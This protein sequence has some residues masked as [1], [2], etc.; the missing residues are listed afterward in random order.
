[1]NHLQKKPKSCLPIR[2]ILKI[3]TLLF[4][5]PNL[6]PLL[7]ITIP[8]YDKAPVDSNKLGIFFSPSAAIDEDIILSMPNLDFDQYIG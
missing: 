7:R 6:D 2:F 8:A 1:M 3:E 4:L 5:L